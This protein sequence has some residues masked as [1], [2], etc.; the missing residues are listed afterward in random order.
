[1]EV[2]GDFVEVC[3][4]CVEAGGDGGEVC[5]EYVEMCQKCVWKFFR[6]V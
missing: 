4:E 5:G 3:G 6:S 1:M 2:F